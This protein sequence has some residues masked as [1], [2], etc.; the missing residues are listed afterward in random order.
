MDFLLN[1]N[2][3]YLF[4]MAGLLLSLMAIVTPGTGL[5]EAGAFSCLAL[6]GYAVYSLSFNLWALIVLALSVVP[7][8][9]AIQKPKREILLGLSL[10]GFVVGSIFL[11]SRENGLPAVNLAVAVAV[12]ALMVGLLWIAVRKSMQAALGRPTHDLTALIGQLGE[13][14]TDIHA[15]GSV[16]ISGE[17]WSARSEQAIPRGSHVRVVRREGFILVVEQEL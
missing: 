15:E 3:A 7:F 17:V 11:F 2:V 12:S 4:L 10:L 6:A 13:A 8:V 1:P 16:Q 14:R 5:I 9:F